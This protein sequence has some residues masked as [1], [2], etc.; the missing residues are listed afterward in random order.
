MNEL[1]KIEY[2]NINILTTKQIAEAYGTDATIISNNFNRNKEKYILGKHY[3]LL[4]NQDKR[5]FISNHHQI[6][7]GSK[8]A[9]KLYLWTEAGAL[10]HAKSLNTDEAWQV[11]QELVD[12]YFRKQEIDI[13]QIFNSDFMFKI[14]NQLKEQENIIA[15]QQEENEIL[16]IEAKTNEPKVIFANSVSTS[17]TSILIRELAKLLTQNG[18]KTGQQRLFK[19]LREE[20]YLISRKAS[21]YNSPT[22]RA[23]NLKL[24]EIKETTINRSDGNITINK[25]VTVTGKGQIYFINKYLNQND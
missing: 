1:N 12:S 11:Y 6:D 5:D 3:Y 24:F 22:Q 8:K 9:T 7:D 21:D 18:Y 2:K 10:L 15:Q 23:M 19:Q 13:P 17:K 14:G 20:G 25:T 16:Q 4:E